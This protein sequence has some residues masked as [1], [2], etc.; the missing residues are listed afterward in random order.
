MM[1]HTQ[2]MEQYSLVYIRAVAILASYHVGRPE[3]DDDSI[4]GY[5]VSREGSRPRI[6]FQAKAMPGDRLPDNDIY[7]SFD[8]KIKNYNDLRAESIVPRL[9]IVVLVPKDCNDWARHDESELVLRRCGYWVSLLGR[10]ETNNTTTVR[11]QI[12]RA[13]I[14]SPDT[15]KLLMGKADRSKSL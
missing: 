6:E 10:P 8:L 4:D 9:L 2:R 7:F 15:L 11:V 1:V 14:L 12:P 13:N 3:V 5:F